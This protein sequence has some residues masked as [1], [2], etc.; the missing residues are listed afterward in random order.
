LATRGLILNLGQ[1]IYLFA[2]KISIL[3]RRLKDDQMPLKANKY[4]YNKFTKAEQMS[5]ATLK[6]FNDLLIKNI[7]LK[8]N[9]IARVIK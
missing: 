7:F 9:E 5:Y 3:Q 1:T 6:L 2:S 8:S 4:L